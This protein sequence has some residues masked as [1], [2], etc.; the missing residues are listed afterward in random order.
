MDDEWGRKALRDAFEGTAMGA[1]WKVG[2]FLE[3]LGHE[4]CMGKSVL[5]G[6]GDG[7][8]LHD[9]YFDKGI[10]GFWHVDLRSEIWRTVNRQAP[11]CMEWG[12]IVLLHVGCC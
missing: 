6:V 9:G 12:W 7:E 10:L 1:A 5:G 3:E 8:V 2:S 4:F 11:R